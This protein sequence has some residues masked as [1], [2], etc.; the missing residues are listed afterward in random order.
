MAPDEPTA[1]TIDPPPQP[2]SPNPPPGRH[3]VRSRRNRYIAGVCGGFGEYFDI[4]PVIFRIAAVALIFAGGGGILLYLLAWLLIP[5]D[6][7]RR[8]IGESLPHRHRWVPIV[9]IGIG[10]LIVLGP[11]GHAGRR[12]DNFLLAVVI[13]GAGAALLYRSQQRDHPWHAGTE[14]ALAAPPSPSAASPSSPTPPSSATPP[15]WPPPPDWVPPHGLDDVE[16]FED[17][18]NPPAVDRPPSATPVLL[19][20]LLLL[21]GGAALLSAVAGVHVSVAAFLA[22]ALILTGLTLLLRAPRGRSRGLIP[23]GVL[24]TLALAVAAVVE[25]PLQRGV[26]QRTWVPM[27]V[28]A[29]REPFRLGAGNATL[30][31]THLRKLAGERV[32]T[33]DVTAGYLKV[34]VPSNVNVIGE[35]RSQ[36]GEVMLFGHSS[37]RG[38]GNHVQ[39]IHHPDPTKRGEP[40]LDLD[41]RVDLGLVEVTNVR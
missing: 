31:L 34:I 30:D 6:G 28:T 16:P 11:M 27:S 25:P 32:I 41:L 13:I 19:S 26:G 24:L 36:I 38:P 2:P 33:A 12:G 1:G 29:L 21:A 5:E 37:T 9:L 3:L 20:F 18:Y 8:S 17:L 14:E 23:L 10:V 22:V 35:A 40:T 15:Y 39:Q 7:R 4:D